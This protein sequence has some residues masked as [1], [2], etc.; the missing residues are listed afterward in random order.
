MLDAYFRATP[1]AG[2]GIV[3]A[4]C[5]ATGLAAVAV[6]TAWAPPL[7]VWLYVASVGTYGAVTMLPD[8][9][10][11]GWHWRSP[12][13]LALV[14]PQWDAWVAG[15]DSATLNVWLGLP[16]GVGAALLALDLRRW[17]PLV[18]A[19]LAPWAAEWWQA[20]MPSG[21][22]GLSGEDLANNL[23][24]IVVGVAIGA[25]ID[26]LLVWWERRMGTDDL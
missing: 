1:L 14:V 6:R 4:L 2:V 20:V 19:L 12:F 26:R 9:W 21:R 22:H 24:G 10:S 17:W 18:V 5:L 8:S 11:R 15:V 23:Y 25:A 16:V 3:L 7:R 13:D